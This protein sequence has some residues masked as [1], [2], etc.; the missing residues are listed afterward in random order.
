MTVTLFEN[1]IGAIDP[2]EMLLHVLVNK[3]EQQIQQTVEIDSRF[4]AF[5][6]SKIDKFPFLQRVFPLFCTLSIRLLK[7]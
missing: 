4:Q 3:F 1:D 6:R 7:K 2:P 5:L